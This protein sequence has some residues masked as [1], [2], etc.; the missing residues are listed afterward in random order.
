MPT[1]AMVAYKLM[2]EI[3]ESPMME[4]SCA[5]ASMA[6]DPPVKRYLNYYLI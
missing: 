5:I 3:K 1:T 2:P 4:P 6:V